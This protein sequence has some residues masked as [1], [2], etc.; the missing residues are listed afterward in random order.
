MATTMARA[1]AVA[2]LRELHKM[3]PYQIL[4]VF[5]GAIAILVGI[6]EYSIGLL[7]TAWIA[8]VSEVFLVVFG[9]LA[10]IGYVVSRA[11]GRN[12]SIVAGIGGL[13]LLVLA[14]GS[15]GL[16]TGILVLIGALWGFA[17]SL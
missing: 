13:C 8:S 17:K 14:G 15:A 3:H 11:H 2:S 9:A 1:R 12:G 6:V 10:L 16:L 5:G 4:I 7:H